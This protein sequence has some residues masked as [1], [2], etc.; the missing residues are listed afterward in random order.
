VSKDSYTLYYDFL[1]EAVTPYFGQHTV[2]PFALAAMCIF[3]FS[4]Y[5]QAPKNV[6]LF[7]FIFSVLIVITVSLARFTEHNELEHMRELLRSGAIS[8]V[9]GPIENMTLMPYHG[10]ALES[11]TV[12]GR[13]FEYSEF[14]LAPGFR[15]TV[16]RSGSILRNGLFVRISYF[17]NYILRIEIKR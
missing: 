14:H 16:A 3:W 17:R 1:Q 6:R 9:E 11:I 2:I 12:Q 10:H 4:K 13:T 8:K 5:L 7:I 15:G